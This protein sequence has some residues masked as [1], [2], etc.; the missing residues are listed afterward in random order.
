[1]TFQTNDTSARFKVLT[2]MTINF[3]RLNRKNNRTN[4]ENVEG[5]E[6]GYHSSLSSICLKGVYL[7][8][9]Y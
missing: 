1:V 2:P 6:G 4:K 9:D 8:E 5:L 7:D 3:V